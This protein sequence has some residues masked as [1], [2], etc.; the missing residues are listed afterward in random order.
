MNRRGHQASASRD[1]FG[2]PTV[3]VACVSD[4]SLLSRLNEA[5]GE[6]LLVVSEFCDLPAALRRVGISLVIVEPYDRIGAPAADYIVQLRRTSSVAQVVV[7]FSPNKNHY[8]DL[9]RLGAA[10]VSRVV[11]KGLDDSPRALR[12]IA[13]LDAFNGLANR[14]ANAVNL[15]EGLRAV[16]MLCLGGLGRNPSAEL[17][18]STIGVSTRTLTKWARRAGFAGIGVFVSRCRVLYAIGAGVERKVSIE[19]LALSLGYGSAGHLSGLVR[20]HAGVSLRRAVTTRSFEEWCEALL[21]DQ[22]PNRQSPLG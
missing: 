21:G 12:E 18:A 16:A 19:S 20:R 7:Y 22:M 11:V 8:S 1:Q 15:D 9:L 5:F 17:L 3:V 14:L 6:S 13:E 4:E 10:G 2:V